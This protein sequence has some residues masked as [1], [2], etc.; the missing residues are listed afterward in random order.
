MKIGC[1]GPQGSYSALAA[2]KLS[3]ASEIILYPTFPAVVKALAT[4][5]VDEIVLPIENTIQGGVLQNMDLLVGEREL[6]AVKEYVMPIEHKLVSKKGVALEKIERVYSHLQAL[7]QCA[8]FL[9]ENLPTA[10][11][12]SVESTAA[13]LQ[14]VKDRGDACIISSYLCQ[15][16]DEN[17]YD[18]YPEN[19]ADEKK[20]FTYFVL[21]RKGERWLQKQSTHVYFAARLPHKAGSLYRL[22]GV[23]E[24]YGLNMTK[25][26]SRPIKN[27][28]GEYRFFIE[29]EGDYLSPVVQNATKDI[30]KVCQD[31]KLLGCY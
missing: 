28:V 23:V 19:I 29:F 18:I 6:F 17:E 10:R 2:E 30:Q 24:S 7:G 14:M 26:E 16:L 27:K 9:S 5:A 25:I 8:V 22:L 3:P 21:V 15:T 1:L 20:N 13:S 31:F 4:G 11:Q 12:I